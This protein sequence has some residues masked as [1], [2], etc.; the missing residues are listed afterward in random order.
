MA[1]TLRAHSF[2]AALITTRD[3]LNH[4]IGKREGW[5]ARVGKGNPQLRA[6]I[7]KSIAFLK[8]IAADHVAQEL[9]A[10]IEKSIA[11]MQPAKA[12]E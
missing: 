5:L 9:R 2:E 8:G 6:E 12:A 3:F 1:G 7:V 11:V 10:E 4:Q